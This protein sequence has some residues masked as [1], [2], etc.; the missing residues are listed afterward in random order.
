[1]SVELFLMIV[2]AGAAV[3]GLFLRPPVQVICLPPD[4]PPKEES[5]EQAPLITRRGNDET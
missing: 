3:I 5:S 4:K 2:G 1:M